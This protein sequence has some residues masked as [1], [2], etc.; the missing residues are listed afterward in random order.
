MSK[1]RSEIENNMKE[2]AITRLSKHDLNGFQQTYQARQQPI[3]VTDLFVGKLISKLNSID[4]VKSV[5]GTESV[6]MSPNY[7]N[8]SQKSIANYYRGKKVEYAGK[9]REVKFDDFFDIASKEPD[10]NW[11]ITE[12]PT[13]ECILDDLDL[14]VLGVEKIASGYGGPKKRELTT[15]RSLMF[16][17]NAG[18]A[19]DLHTDWDGRDVVLYQSS[20]VKRV[21]LFPPEAAMYLMPIDIFSTVKLNG[22]P[23]RERQG[24]VESLGGYDFLLYPGEAVYMPAFFWHHLEYVEQ[25]LSFNFRFGGT[26]DPDVLFLSVSYHRDMYIQNLLAKFFRDSQ[27]ES[28]R[29]AIVKLCEAYHRPYSTPKTKYRVL[30]KL[31]R[32]IYYQ[33]CHQSPKYFTW[34]NCNDFLDGALHFRYLQPDPEWGRFKKVTW[35]YGERLRSYIRKIAYRLADWV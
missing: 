5:L 25:G 35:V 3:V 10:K 22:M 27:S 34:I 29:E 12:S 9:S 23:E 16:F 24:L 26:T 28:H 31:G 21:T 32:E 13:P 1:I 2:T 18:N 20:G 7:V 15:A 6:Q 17:T 30:T 19:S 11:I 8:I 4:K 14:G 33:V